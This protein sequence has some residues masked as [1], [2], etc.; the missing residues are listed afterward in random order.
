MKHHEE[1]EVSNFDY[2]YY[3]IGMLSGA[4]TGLILDKGLIWAL[5]GAVLGLLSGGLYLTVLVKGRA[6]V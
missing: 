4:F 5:V 3:V 1:E 6:D 2:L